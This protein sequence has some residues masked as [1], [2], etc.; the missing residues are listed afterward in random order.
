MLFND[1]GDPEEIAFN[2]RKV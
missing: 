2:E 1:K